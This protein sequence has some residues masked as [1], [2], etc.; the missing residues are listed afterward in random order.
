MNSNFSSGLLGQGLSSGDVGV[1]SPPE[2][3]E[4][5]VFLIVI[6]SLCLAGVDGLS[7]APLGRVLL[8]QR[9]LPVHKPPDCILVLLFLAL[10]V[11]LQPGLEHLEFG[12]VDE[13]SVLFVAVGHVPVGNLKPPDQ[14][15]SRRKY[16][17]IRLVASFF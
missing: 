12:V 15:I 13:P 11:V 1:G 7:S 14:R 6:N 4:D 17:I 16:A 5:A 2:V 3:F 9:L 10:D 8:F